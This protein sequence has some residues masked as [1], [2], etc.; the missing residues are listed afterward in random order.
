MAVEPILHGSR[1]GLNC[2]TGLRGSQATRIGLCRVA[3]Y[4]SLAALLGACLPDLRPW[5]PAMSTSSPRRPTPAQVILGLFILWQLFFIPAANLFEFVPHRPAQNDELTELPELASGTQCPSKVLGTVASALDRWAE[6][7][8]QY[9]VWWLFAPHFPS[10]VAFPAVE[11]RWDDDALSDKGCT[12]RVE[13]LTALAHSG[14]VGPEVA[15]GQ[16]VPRPPVRLLS[17]F[18][19]KDPRSYVRLPGSND[20]LFHYEGRL[21]LL[22]TYWDDE[23]AT[24]QQ[25]EWRAAVRGRVQRQWKSIRAYLRWRLH[26]FRAQNPDVPEPKEMVLSIRIYRTPPP[27]QRSWDQYGPIEKPLAR[28]RPAEDGPADYLPVE[29]C[30]PFDRRFVSLPR[31]E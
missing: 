4:S 19:P 7:T 26:E 25:D 24:K 15:S 29:A 27:G 6:C 28:W 1:N 10:Q 14:T 5:N 9:Q 18:D 31:A 21:G 12:S 16:R 11:L 22:L 23:A 20:R 30:D 13:S 3:T 17:L 2:R 8:G